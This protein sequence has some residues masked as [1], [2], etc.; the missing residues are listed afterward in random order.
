MKIVCIS[1]LHNVYTDLILPKGDVL[2]VAGDIDTHGGEIL[3][4]AFNFWMCSLDYK[5]KIVIAGN[6]DKYFAENNVR[7]TPYIYLN[8][9]GVEIE[10]VKFYGSP[11]SPK[12]GHWSFMKERGDESAKVWDK[13][14]D[15]TDVLITHGP[16]YGI[17]D[18]TAFKQKVGCYDL[19]QRV[20]KVQPKYHI[21]GHIH[22]A[23]GTEKIG[24]TTFINASVVDFRYNL[25]NNPVVIEI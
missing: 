10:G 14:P 5:Y 13:I 9:S 12:F 2:I 21:F 24:D 25:K 6:H 17:L 22:E 8:N 23:Y 11:V 18:E 19:L 16:P 7:S 20:L 15:D 1:D 4:L 3:F